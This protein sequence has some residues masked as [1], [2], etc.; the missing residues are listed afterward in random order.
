MSTFSG[1]MSFFGQESL[2]EA[3]SAVKRELS[4]DSPVRSNH[5]YVLRFAQ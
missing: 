3:W 1:E 2:E 4:E 5:L